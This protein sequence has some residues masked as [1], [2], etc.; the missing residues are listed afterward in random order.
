MVMNGSTDREVGVSSVRRGGGGERLAR[1]EMV[2][3]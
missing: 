2:R 1:G 3:C